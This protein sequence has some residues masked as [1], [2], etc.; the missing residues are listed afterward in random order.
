MN[1]PDHR[2]RN[3]IL[4]LGHLETQENKPEPPS[5]FTCPFVHWPT[6]LIADINLRL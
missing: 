3:F 6:M 1:V 4:V 5:N 2:A